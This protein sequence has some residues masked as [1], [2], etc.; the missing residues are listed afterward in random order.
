MLTLAL[1]KIVC[2]LFNINEVRYTEIFS[3]Y[4]KGMTMNSKQIFNI[5]KS[6]AMLNIMCCCCKVLEGIYGNLCC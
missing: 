4:K 1:D 5:K 6:D 3:L 2:L